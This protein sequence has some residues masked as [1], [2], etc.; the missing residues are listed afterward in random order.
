[1]LNSVRFGA[2]KHPVTIDRMT[3]EKRLGPV[4]ERTTYPSG[5]YMETFDMYQHSSAENYVREAQYAYQQKAFV[6]EGKGER[7]YAVTEGD[8][9][10]LGN[11]LKTDATLNQLNDEVKQL[12]AQLDAAEE[13]RDAHKSGLV[14]AYLDQNTDRIQEVPYKFDYRTEPP[15]P[16]KRSLWARLFGS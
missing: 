8:A 4:R 14:Q 13:K 11:V 16:P 6:A 2:I 7:Q 12:Q 1:M 15:P 5:T 3:G 9:E 10:A